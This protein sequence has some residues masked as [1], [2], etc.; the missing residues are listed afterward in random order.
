MANNPAETP[1][2][3]HA[4]SETGSPVHEDKKVTG[5]NQNNT[6]IKKTE[7]RPAAMAGPAA[8]DRGEA[9]SGKVPS[10]VLCG[11]FSLTDGR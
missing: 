3:A 4:G 11:I 1:N 10:A 6:G 8:A 9:G 5:N 7:M 2:T